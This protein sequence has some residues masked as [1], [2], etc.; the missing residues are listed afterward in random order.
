M[1]DSDP[2]L[3]QLLAAIGPLNDAAPPTP[4]PAQSPW[5]TPAFYL[6]IIPQ[7]SA[8]LLLFFHRDFGL[9]SAATSIAFLAAALVGFGAYIARAFKHHASGQS[10][11]AY[12]QAIAAALAALTP[13]AVPA[14][15]IPIS[16]DIVIN[17]SGDSSGLASASPRKTTARKTTARRR[18]ER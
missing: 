1:T 11:A 10:Y 18:T 13:P 7:L 12:L 17:S 3:Q 6:A 14:P 15:A 16:G 9:N 2:R 4:A 8:V 5:A